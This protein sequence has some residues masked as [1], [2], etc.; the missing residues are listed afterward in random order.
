MK[1]VVITISGILFL[2][3]LINGQPTSQV[4]Q[5]V[6]QNENPDVSS[7][8]DFFG[9]YNNKEK[10][11]NK[12]YF[13]FA[14][15]MIQQPLTPW[16]SGTVILVK[17]GE[18]L[19]IKAGEVYALFYNLPLSMLIQ[20]GKFHTD[21]GYINKLHK[22]ELPTFNH[23]PV[24]YYIFNSSY[25]NQNGTRTLTGDEPNNDVGVQISTLLP[26]LFY[27]E[28]EVGFLNG[29]NATIL[30]GGSDAIN[31]Y[32]LK[33]KNYWDISD[34]TELNL[35]FSGLSGKSPVGNAITYVGS[36]YLGLKIKSKTLPEF[37]YL[38]FDSE[39]YYR[40]LIDKKTVLDKLMGYYARILYEFR[41]LYQHQIGVQFSSTIP[42]NI[43]N[44]PID[45]SLDTFLTMKI[46]R[47]TEFKFDWNANITDTKDIAHNMYL[48]FTFTL[49]PHRHLI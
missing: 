48:E 24:L 17:P 46:F 34:S 15:L 7:I 4:Q 31:T 12:F 14:S 39:F 23:P 40:T 9:L 10:T 25:A 49:G 32:L 47:N 36:S 26:F 37:Q 21:F 3:S 43:K 44:K 2:I 33:S 8:I 5:I 1:K 29:N 42:E 41:I 30:R 18:G 38:K 11:A 16:A 22:H 27:S 6:P 28:L 35:W 19:T 13:R 45:N 20:M